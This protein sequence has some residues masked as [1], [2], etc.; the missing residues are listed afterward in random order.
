MKENVTV[1]D[2]DGVVVERNPAIQPHAVWRY[3]LE[4]NKIFQPPLEIP[5]VER[6]INE[7][8]QRSITDC[9]LL[10]LARHRHVVNGVKEML[11][12]RGG[13][14]YVNTGRP[15]KKEWIEVTEKTLR[16]AQ[17]RDFFQDIYYRRP[18]LTT[19]E[20]KL[21]VVNE[22]YQR[23]PPD[24]YQITCVDDNPADALPIAKAFP[25]VQVVV[26]QDLSSGI[27]FSRVEMRDY[28][29]VRRVARGQLRNC[30]INN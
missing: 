17:I 1:Y 28:P 27:L 2:F 23:Y 16:D 7:D 13:A 19:M 12:A 18:E 3:L 14:N 5:N 24:K 8:G 21:A 4:G 9:L 15:N 20:S 26:V 29:N 22:L 25:D 11:M 10:Y 6:A 30:L